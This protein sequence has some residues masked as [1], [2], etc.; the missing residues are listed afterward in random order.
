MVKLPFL[1]AAA[2]LLAVVAVGGA[3]PP[4][5]LPALSLEDQDG[6]ALH[7]A[8]LRGRV[9][10]IVYGA[11]D[12]RDHHVEWGRRLHGEM[13]DRGLYRADDPPAQ[14]PVR[15][16]AV[17]EMG[18]IPS[19]FRSVIR[20]LLRDHVPPGFSLYLDWEDRMSALFGAHRSL[21]TVVVGD[22]DGGV[23]L[24]TVGRPRDDMLRSIVEMVQR[25]T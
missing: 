2:A 13:I 5:S 12:G 14:R 1:V 9:V 4:A 20:G 24:V 7:L 17:A 8:E 21:S 15:I 10:V 11:R 25:L 18:G 16:L 19:A 22:R 23:R 6:N 3:D